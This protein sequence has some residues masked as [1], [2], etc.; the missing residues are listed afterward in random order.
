MKEIAAEFAPQLDFLSRVS[1]R[2]G[3]AD[4]V[5]EY[6]DPLVGDWADLRAEAE[7]WRKAAHVTETVTK[8]VAGPLGSV[9]AAW[10]GRDAESFVEHMRTVGLA[11]TDMSDAMTAMAEA[12]EE[13]ADTVRDIVR[14][15]GRVLA[16]AAESVSGAAALPLDGDHAVVK[17][18][19]ELRTPVRELFES[20]RDVLEAFLKLCDGLSGEDGGF[21]AVTMKHRYPETNWSYTPPAAPKGPAQTPEKPAEAAKT[22]AAGV[23]GGSGA[24][25][26]GGSISAA[27]SG[28]APESHQQM[29]P[30]GSTAVQEPHHAPEPAAHPA[31]AAATGPAGGPQGA[32]GQGGMM[33]PMMGGA[34]GGQQG[35]DK[36]HKRKQQ[37]TGSVDDLLG[38]PKKA[39]PKVIGED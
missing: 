31:A 29:Q 19:E 7:R 27:L 15:M 26:G 14:D 20:A 23:G 2:V 9:D 32:G 16:D 24:H 1:R 38:K 22:A 17:H 18:V 8:H 3:V 5:E 34:M 30:G 21:G 36:E 4:L 35:G 37:L 10:Q 25:G 33:G 28:G 39:S 13:T 6:F 11:G 12:L